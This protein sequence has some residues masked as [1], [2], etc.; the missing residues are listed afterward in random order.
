[1]GVLVCGGEESPPL[2]FSPVEGEK[3]FGATCWH[4]AVSHDFVTIKAL[5]N[6]GGNY[7]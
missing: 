1:M 7:G 2:S 5:G 6:L 4:S 3:R